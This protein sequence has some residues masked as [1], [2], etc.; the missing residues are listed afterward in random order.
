MSLSAAPRKSFRETQFEL[1]REAILDATNRLLGEKG[2]EAMAM[3]DIAAEV[4]VA[5]GSL[6]KHFESKEAL[7]GAVM[8]RLLRQTGDAL[9]GLD[10]SQPAVARLEALLRWTLEQRL[11]GGV[12]HLPSTSKALQQSLMAN[13][14]YL[15][16][17]MSLS[18]R[19]GAMIAQARRDGDIDAA[20]GDDMILFSLYARTCDP[21]LEFLKAGGSM[22]DEA[23]VEQ[24]TRSCFHGLCPARR[25]D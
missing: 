6:Y 21:T 9:D 4:G 8:T 12:P 16:E 17:V 15:D 23:I 14:A 24:L 10:A 20:L 5:K 25:G 1:R 19:I 11:Q 2:F 22:S 18:D 7:A 13:S 3:D